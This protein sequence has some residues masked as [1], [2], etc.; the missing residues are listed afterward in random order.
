FA[1]IGIQAL[2]DEATGYQ[3]IRGRDA[4]QAMLDAFLSKELAAWAKRFPDEF[5]RQIFRLRGWKWQGR[6]VN[7]PQVVGKYTDMIVYQRLAPNIV[8]NLRT[9]NPK[10][11]RGNRANK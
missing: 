8:E 4:L 6:A 3:D 10:N 1:A 9:L 11:D 2:V 7:P 5:Y